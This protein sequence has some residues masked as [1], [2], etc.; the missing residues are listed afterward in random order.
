VNQVASPRSGKAQCAFI[1]PLWPAFQR[2]RLPLKMLR[3]LADSPDNGAARPQPSGHARCEIP[4]LACV[5]LD[6]LDEC[7]APKRFCD[8]GFATAR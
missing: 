7:L 2:G 1:E 5:A 4:A 3:C 8:I 6:Q